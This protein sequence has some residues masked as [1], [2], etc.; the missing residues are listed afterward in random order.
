MTNTN[1]TTTAASFHAGFFSPQGD[2][3]MNTAPQT[4]TA[5]GITFNV[6]TFTVNQPEP[7]LETPLERAQSEVDRLEAWPEVVDVMNEHEMG[8]LQEVLHWS[9]KGYRLSAH[10]LQSFEPG[11]FYILMFAPGR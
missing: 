2:N 10:S 5:N 7:R 6:T 1:T 9:A 8:F 4:I 3:K 11:N